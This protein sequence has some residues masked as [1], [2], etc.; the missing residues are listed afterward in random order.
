MPVKPHIL[1]VLYVCIDVKYCEWWIKL[2]CAF[3]SAFT[4]SAVSVLAVPSHRWH[5]GESSTDNYLEVEALSAWRHIVPCRDN[6][7]AVTGALFLRHRDAFFS[8]EME[9]FCLSF[10]TKTS[11]SPLRSTLFYDIFTSE[12]SWCQDAYIPEYSFN[13]E[14]L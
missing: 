14:I 4:S 12:L 5:R 8:A 1:R 6:A 3:P 10:D 11:G 9:N 7:L 13:V 2:R